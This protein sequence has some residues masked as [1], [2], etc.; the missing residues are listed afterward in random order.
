ME[1]RLVINYI[2]QARKLSLKEFKVVSGEAQIST[3]VV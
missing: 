2:I 1:P 3:Q